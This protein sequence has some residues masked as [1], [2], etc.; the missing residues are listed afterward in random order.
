MR[1]AAYAGS[2]YP[3]SANE[4]FSMIGGCFKAKLGPGF[5]PIKPKLAPP[6]LKAIISP[7]AGYVYSGMAAAW[8]Y[9]AIAESSLPDLFIMLGPNH[10]SFES[11]MSLE[12]FETPLGLVN[13]DREFGKLLASKGSLPVNEKI[14]RDEHSIEVQIPFLQFSLANRTEKIKM[15]PILVSHDL[16]LDKVAKDMKE[17]IA[18]SGKKVTFI[19]SSD[20]THYGPSYGYA[21]FRFQAGSGLDIKKLI[22]DLDA[23]AIE[24]IKSADAKGFE[25]YINKTKATVCGVLPI[26]LLLKT[27]TFK[28][29]SLEKYYL[30]GDITGDYTNTV[31]YASISF[32]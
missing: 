18:E 30:S 16:D 8:G 15:L 5:L 20:F 7:H 24:F 23:K 13:L 22:S 25:D 26:I 17:A 3:S 10:H 2:F 12:P 4:L 9:K 21:P 14:H 28:K 11:G 27:I 6:P 31:S 1:K 29:A 19:V 32:R